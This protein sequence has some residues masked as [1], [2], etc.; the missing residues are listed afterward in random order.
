MGAAEAEE[1]TY[2]MLGLLDEW[3]EENTDATTERRQ[4]VMEALYSRVEAAY[5]KLFEVA[6]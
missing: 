2:F 5:G 4:T 3:L 1:L 6:F